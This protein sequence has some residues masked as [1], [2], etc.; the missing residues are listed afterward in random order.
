M[1]KIFAVFDVKAAQF[2]TPIFCINR[3]VALRNFSDVCAKPDSM[4]CQHSGDYSLYELGEYDPSTGKI[5]ALVP[6]AIFVSASDVVA[7]SVRTAGLAEHKLNNVKMV[8][9]SKA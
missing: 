3:G 1:L 9:G 5:D 8:A 2:G 4:L 7:A 6:P